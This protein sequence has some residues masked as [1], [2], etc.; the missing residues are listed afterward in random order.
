MTL[1]IATM[2][3]IDCGRA[4]KSTRGFSVA[5]FSEGATPPYLYWGS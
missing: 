2:L 4:S 5:L 1:Q 3:L